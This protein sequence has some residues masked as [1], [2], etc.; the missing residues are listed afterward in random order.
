MFP[1]F[2]RSLKYLIP[3]LVE[4]KICG[5]WVSASFIILFNG[6]WVVLLKSQF[7]SLFHVMWNTVEVSRRI[8]P[9]RF[10]YD[11]F[12]F[13]RRSWIQGTVEPPHPFWFYFNPN[14]TDTLE[15]TTFSDYIY[16]FAIPIWGHFFAQEM[17][18]EW[19]K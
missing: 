10:S 12:P 19:H 1:P 9:C 8:P 7:Y 18:Q 16:S 11:P 13:S 14:I 17:R 15:N 4:P 5:I 2:G 3:V 6:I